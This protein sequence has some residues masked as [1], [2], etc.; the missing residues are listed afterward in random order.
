MVLF[1]ESVDLNCELQDPL[2][3]NIDPMAP[4][5]QMGQ[6]LLVFHPVNKVLALGAVNKKSAG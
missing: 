2:V 4:H 5:F 3:R 1:R 6:S